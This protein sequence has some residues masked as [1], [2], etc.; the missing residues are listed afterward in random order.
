MIENITIKDALLIGFAQVF[1]LIPGFS[2]SGTT[3]AMAR[4][5]KINRSDAAKFSFFLSAPVVFGAVFL[6][7]VKGEMG[8][9][10]SYDIT[11]FIIGVVVSFVMGMICISFL[12]RYIKKH[13]YKIFMWYRLFMALAVLIVLY[14]R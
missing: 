7:V 10:I 9:L 6:K 14:L 3:I 13:D 12:M 8:S 11:S 1:A 4:T 5:L 2:R